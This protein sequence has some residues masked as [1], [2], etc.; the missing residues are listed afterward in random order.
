MVELENI[1][2]CYGS[3]EDQ[4]VGEE[5]LSDI[6]L[7]V[8]DGEFVLLTGP[9]GCGKTT[10]LRLINGLIPHF[11]PGK[12]S[13]RVLIDGEDILTKELYEL[14]LAAGTVFQNPRTQFYN[15][16]TTGELAF[17]CENRGLPESEIC[18]RIDSTVAAFGIE[19]LMDRNIFKLSG[20]EKQK[21]ALLRALNSDARILILDEA[22]A[23]YDKQSDAMFNDFIMNN[24]DFF[25]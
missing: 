24:H 13:G 4:A 10:V 23:N 9:S 3:S 19:N 16:D 25:R 12:I 5:I 7:T 6:D 14:G 8:R 21:I 17:G 22:T 15:V 11:Y 2:F 18:S 1:S 20:G